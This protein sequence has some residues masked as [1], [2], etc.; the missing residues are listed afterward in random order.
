MEITLVGLN[1]SGKTRFVNVIASSQDSED[2]I[3]TIGF[4]MKK[5]TKGKGGL[6]IKVKSI[7]S[8]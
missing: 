7:K 8:F 4:N 6:T 3:P 1:D 2:S 5:I